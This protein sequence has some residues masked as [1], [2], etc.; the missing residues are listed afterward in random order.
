MVEHQDLAIITLPVRSQST[1]G[2]ST[3]LAVLPVELRA[4]PGQHTAGLPWLA[5]ELG[6]PASQPLTLLVKVMNRAGIPII[7][8][9]TE[10]MAG[11]RSFVFRDLRALG[12]EA[13]G[14]FKDAGR[15]QIGQRVWSRRSYAVLTVASGGAGGG[16]P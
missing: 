6:A 13:Y 10:V 16:R 12:I 2:S 8:G 3:R 5:G 4:D 11:E 9:R 14:H 15:E 7:E 1:R